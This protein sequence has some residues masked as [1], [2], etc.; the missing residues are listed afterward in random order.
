MKCRD[1]AF[2][3]RFRPLG[4]STLDRPRSY[5]NAR[6]SVAAATDERGTAFTA[7]CD[8]H[9]RAS[10]RAFRAARGYSDSE[11]AGREKCGHH[12]RS[13][14][15]GRRGTGSTLSVVWK[16]HWDRGHPPI[17]MTGPPAQRGVTYDVGL[18]VAES[19]GDSPA[20]AVLSRPLSLR[21]S[22]QRCPNEGHAAPRSPLVRA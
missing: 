13:L 18:Q 4:G 7:L 17:L 1:S 15:P 22:V 6:S 9:H 19:L 21:S 11:S 5:R 16:S 3:N 10:C 2:C 12:P 14:R 20:K 8:S